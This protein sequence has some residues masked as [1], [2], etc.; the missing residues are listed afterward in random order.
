MLP[1]LTNHCVLVE[2]GDLSVLLKEANPLITSLSPLAQ[3][4][5]L[6]LGESVRMTKLCCAERPSLIGEVVHNVR[7]SWKIWC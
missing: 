4:G 7:V 1:Y 5:L 2:Q 3:D 6:T